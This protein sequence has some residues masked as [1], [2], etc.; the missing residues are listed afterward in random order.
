LLSDRKTPLRAGSS[1][2]GAPPLVAGASEAAA[3]AGVVAPVEAAS[4]T[5]R[6]SRRRR[7]RRSAA[8]AGRGRRARRRDGRG[9]R[10]SRLGTGGRI[11]AARRGGRTG[12]A[13]FDLRVHHAGIRPRDVERD[14]PVGARR[15]AGAA[16][17]RPRPAAVDGLPQCA[18]GTAAVEAAAAPAPLVARRVQDVG[19]RRIDRDVGEPGVLVDEFDLVPGLA[20]VGGLEDAAL[21]VR[22]EQMAGRRDIDRVGLLR[23]NYDARDRLRLLQAD[24]R[25]GLSAVDRLV[26]AVAERRRLAVVRLARADVD[27][28]RIG[29]MDRDVADRC[30][31]VGLEHRRERGAVVVRLE[32]AA[33]RVADVDDVRIRLGHRDIVDASAHACRSDRSK[34]ERL[35]HRIGR[36]VDHP[37]LFLAGLREHRG[38]EQRH[39]DERQSKADESS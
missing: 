22:A 15:Q 13:R 21:R 10:R 34:P 29:R 14:A 11:R 18:A 5:A 17:L 4:S 3:R 2:G 26:D 33:R 25:E 35:Q 16:D 24:V 28:V 32:H 39:D 37:R 36:L 38:D 23:I 6:G 31:A 12:R 27:D 9:P 30:A 7:G 20:A 19:V 8:S 1:A